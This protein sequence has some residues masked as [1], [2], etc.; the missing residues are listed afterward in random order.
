LTD[1]KLSGLERGEAIRADFTP[2][3]NL[4]RRRP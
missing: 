1:E 2:A 4:K 3:R